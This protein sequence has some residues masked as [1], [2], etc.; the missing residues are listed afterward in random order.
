[1]YNFINTP[2][3]MHPQ[4]VQEFALRVRQS[5][6]RQVLASAGVSAAGQQRRS[7]VIDLLIRVLGGPTLF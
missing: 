1:M 5:E 6:K 2:T 3:E 4:S 7:A